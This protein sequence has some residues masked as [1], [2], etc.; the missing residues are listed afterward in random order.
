MCYLVALLFTKLVLGCPFCDKTMLYKLVDLD[1]LGKLSEWCC[2]LIR[3]KYSC[4]E[5]SV[6]SFQVRLISHR[7]RKKF[8]CQP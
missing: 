8:V 1:C 3:G 2:C 6:N 4:R 5:Q 7:M